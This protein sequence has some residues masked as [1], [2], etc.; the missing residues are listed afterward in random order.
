MYK[1]VGFCDIFQEGS[2][3]LSASRLEQVRLPS[4]FHTEEYNILRPC[5]VNATMAGRL[6]L[7]GQ[8]R[9][10]KTL[11]HHLMQLGG[12]VLPQY[13]V[14]LAAKGSIERPW[15]LVGRG[16]LVVACVYVY[17]SLN[18]DTKQE[19]IDC[20]AQY[21]VERLADYRCEKDVVS[22]QQTSLDPG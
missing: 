15:C 12:V 2:I 16:C 10:R 6:I 21:E 14:F 1:D 22:S 17:S 5:K 11:G 3:K 20:E 7:R 9:S 4:V 19:T 8:T 18:E 13:V